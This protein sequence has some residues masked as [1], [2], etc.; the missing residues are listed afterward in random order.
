MFSMSRLAGMVSRSFADSTRSKSVVP[1]RFC[2]LLH[3][4]EE[5]VIVG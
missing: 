1:T 2:D 3:G 5:R 4:G